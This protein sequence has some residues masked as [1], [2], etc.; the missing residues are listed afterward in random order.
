MLMART[1]DV[2]PRWS[3]PVDL[4]CIYVSGRQDFVFVEDHTLKKGYSSPCKF[5]HIYSVWDAEPRGAETFSF[6]QLL[7]PFLVTISVAPGF[8]YIH[9]VDGFGRRSSGI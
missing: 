9:T 4:G 8:P 2:Q 7:H 3:A 5:V 6:L 1:M